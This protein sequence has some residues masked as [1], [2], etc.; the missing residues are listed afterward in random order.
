MPQISW[1]CT[2]PNLSNKNMYPRFLRTVAP[3]TTIGMAY[4]QVV[5]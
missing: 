2:S 4:A 1:G 3:D 5:R